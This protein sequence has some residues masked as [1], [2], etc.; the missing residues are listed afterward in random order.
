METKL[1]A[2]PG[3]WSSDR[4]AS[5]HRAPWPLSPSSP[6]QLASRAIMG[7]EVDDRGLEVQEKQKD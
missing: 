1:L 3:A 6:S 2:F 5:L 7:T 4:E